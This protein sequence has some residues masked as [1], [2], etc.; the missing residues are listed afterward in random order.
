MNSIG[1]ESFIP[2]LH[3]V[4]SSRTV[5]MIHA[6]HFLTHS[7]ATCSRDHRSPHGDDATTCLFSHRIAVRYRKS[8]PQSSLRFLVP[9]SLSLLF[10]ERQWGHR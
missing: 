8:S 7:L 1:Y 4:V 5:Q 6:P 10:R 3:V 2:N 9:E